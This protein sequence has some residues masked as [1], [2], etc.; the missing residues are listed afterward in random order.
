MTTSTPGDLQRAFDLHRANKL[1]EAID[2][3]RAVL[4]TH[5][6]HP[7]A[8]HF[9]GYALHQAGQTDEALPLLEASV[10]KAPRNAVYRN[11]YGG[12]LRLVGQLEEA[13]TQ[14]TQ[15]ISIQPHLAPAYYNLGL[16]HQQMQKPEDAASAYRQATTLNPKYADAWLRLGAVLKLTGQHKEAVEAFQKGLQLKPD[17]F[18]GILAIGQIASRIKQYPAAREHFER[19][20][21]LKPDSIEALNGLAWAQSAMGEHNEACALVQEKV[22]PV[23]GKDIA[24]LLNYAAILDA[25][26]RQ[27]DAADTYQRVLDIQPDHEVAR[28]QLAAMRGETI[29]TPPRSYVAELFGQYAESFDAHMQSLHCNIP[30]LVADAVGEVAPGR[31][32]VA[33]DLGCG[34]GLSGVQLAPR[35]TAMDGVDLSPE[36]LTKARAREIYRDLYCG[37]LDAVLEQRA[38]QYDLIA[39]ADVFIYVGDLA[40]VF[41]AA[42]AALKPGGLFAF[43]VESLEGDS[44][45]LRPSRRY[46]HSLAYIRKLAADHGFIERYAHQA[47]LRREKDE[48]IQGHIIVLERPNTPQ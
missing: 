3:Y 4:A 27:S 10:K 35:I 45:Q 38:G 41:P 28:Y 1:P 16:V 44:F 9:L 43:S 6:D 47:P 2:A 23:A 37:E 34:T 24:T 39:S 18:A 8:T 29:P 21:K 30:K 46:A 15:A 14:F 31:R 33:M 19:A 17:D 40:S 7:D 36:M 13:R 42:F 25:A 12:V 11:N 32:F 22:L 26:G 48:F 20:L 5:P